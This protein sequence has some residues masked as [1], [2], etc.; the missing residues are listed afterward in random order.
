MKKKKN[1]SYP[2]HFLDEKDATGV[3]T[4]RIGEIGHD[5]NGDTANGKKLLCEEEVKEEEGHNEE[6]LQS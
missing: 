3:R 4:K 2:R 6:I 5:D 1:V